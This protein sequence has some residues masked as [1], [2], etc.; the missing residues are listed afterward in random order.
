MRKDNIEDILKYV[1]AQ[2]INDIKDID[3]VKIPDM[4][5]T[6]KILE[7][8]IYMNDD[9][10]YDINK[11]YASSKKRSFMKIGGIAAAAIFVFGMFNSTRLN[12]VNNVN[13]NPLS[14]IAAADKSNINKSGT[15]SS[16]E[17]KTALSQNEKRN[18]NINSKGEDINNKDTNDV[19]K[20]VNKTVNDSD[21]DN[22]NVKSPSTNSQSNNNVSKNE[23]S[24]K[25]VSEVPDDNIKDSSSKDNNID[26]ND[27]SIEQ[28]SS[29][30]I[31]TASNRDNDLDFKLPKYIPEEY[32][33]DK[34]SVAYSID[35]KVIEILYKDSEDNKL[36]IREIQI[37]SEDNND[38]GNNN[39][40]GS[41]Q[42]NNK[43]VDKDINEKENTESSTSEDAGDNIGKNV[44]NDAN[45]DEDNN[46]NK[47]T[48]DSKKTLK[49]QLIDSD[50]EAKYEVETRV[51]NDIKVI[52]CKDCED[53]YKAYWND[54]KLGYII[55]AD[56][57][58][59]EEE[60]LKIVKGLQW[61]EE[62]TKED[63]NNE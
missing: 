39:N 10:D 61:E 58:L 20:D 15:N 52:L 40:Q 29:S 8:D 4:N 55:K 26:K 46:T 51:I 16:G 5:K 3:N 24:K 14:N 44:D 49:E 13:Q 30:Y 60:M 34:V 28:H 1:Y 23:T 42:V 33:N 63:T 41:Q 35:K 2:G 31:I 54:N 25:E 45:K 7:E 47:I 38:G 19:S 43:Q 17:D 27:E 62:K 36:E 18:E 59:T 48:E 6:F 56:N 21:K 9:N 53:F 12:N 22:K 37:A 11:R 57:P 50:D 32:D